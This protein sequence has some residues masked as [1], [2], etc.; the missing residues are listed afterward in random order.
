MVTG[1][2]PATALHSDRDLADDA[3]TLTARTRLT[4]MCRSFLERGL[5]V[6][7]TDAKRL[8]FSLEEMIRVAVISLT[9]AGIF[10]A[11]TSGMRQD[12]S[13]QSADIRDIKT[14]MEM[15]VRLAEAQARLVDERMQNMARS[16]DGME[17]R[18][19]LL[20]LQYEQLREAML[21]QGILR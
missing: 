4:G 7:D 17:R 9:V 15:Q 3:Q 8:S 19:E 20:R 21:K 12:M 1:A 2:A 5:G 10:W 13:A 6:S 18:Q 14:T 11:T 16:F